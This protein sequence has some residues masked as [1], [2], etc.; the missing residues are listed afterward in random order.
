MILVTVGTERFP[1]DRLVRT[2][3]QAASQLNGESIF[4][5]L[6]HSTYLPMRCQWTRFLAYQALIEQLQQA[7]VVVSHAGAGMLVLCAR[8]GKVPIVIPRRR[9]FGEHVD[10]HQM[11]LATRMARSGFA[12]LAEPLEELVPLL[13]KDGQWHTQMDGLHASSPG[14]AKALGAYL[15][16]IAAERA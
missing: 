1:F 16:E 9:R 7:R 12:V 11:G 6:G 10:D 5:Q 14:L 2:V 15:N 13:R 8:L 3:D 4:V